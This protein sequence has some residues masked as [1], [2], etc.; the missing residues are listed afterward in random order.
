MNPCRQSSLTASEGTAKETGDGDPSVHTLR[1]ISSGTEKNSSKIDDDTLYMPKI[2]HLVNGQCIA[3]RLGKLPSTHSVPS[4]WDSESR[5]INRKQSGLFPKMPNFQ[6]TAVCSAYQSPS[7]A[8]NQAGWS[9]NKSISNLVGQV[10][11]TVSAE[12]SDKPHCNPSR[13]VTQERNRNPIPNQLAKTMRLQSVGNS[14]IMPLKRSGGRQNATDAISIYATKRENHISSAQFRSLSASAATNLKSLTDKTTKT[15][16]VVDELAGKMSLLNSRPN[17]NRS[18]LARSPNDRRNK[19]SRSVNRTA[20]GLS[21]LQFSQHNS[22]SRK[23]IS[24]ISS[25]SSKPR[26]QRSH[27]PN[28]YESYVN[29]NSFPQQESVKSAWR[30]SLFE[31]SANTERYKEH[32]SEH[33]QTFVN[34]PVTNRRQQVARA[35][36]PCRYPN[37][38]PPAYDSLEAIPPIR[39]MNAQLQ[40]WRTQSGEGEKCN[41]QKTGRNVVNYKLKSYGNYGKISSNKDTSS[42]LKNTEEKTDDSSTVRLNFA[43]QTVDSE[44]NLSDLDD[45]TLDIIVGRWF[46]INDDYIAEVDPATFSRVFEGP[47]CAY[48]LFYRN[49][50]LPVL[51]NSA[52]K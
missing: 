48:M 11:Q 37:D 3:S 23:R 44:K 29:L 27:R 51:V 9:R 24:S 17:P 42:N 10:Q 38:P 14:R 41:S 4:S 1:R 39:R 43:Q 6:P 25:V 45:E 30:S 12:N 35:M 46:D 7:S 31:G 26:S 40:S 28:I 36:E 49:M 2:T 47:E 22:L 20:D 19:H 21:A 13:H 8:Q 5:L 34:D 52:S 18:L 32:H 15:R 50:G 16:K 33:R